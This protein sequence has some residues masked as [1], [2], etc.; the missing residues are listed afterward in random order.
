MEQYLLMA[1]HPVGKHT[2]WKYV[3][4]CSLLGILAVGG[5]IVQ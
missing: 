5:E 2:L 3:E 1:R 4:Q